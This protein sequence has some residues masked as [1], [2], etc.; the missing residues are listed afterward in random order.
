MRFGKLHTQITE[1]IAAIQK[2]EINSAG[3]LMPEGLLVFIP[4]K[5]LKKIG[6]RP[7]IIDQLKNINGDTLNK[8]NRK[9]K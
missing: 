4:E 9:T 1:M 8:I 2:E 6:A 5:A 3:I 7:H